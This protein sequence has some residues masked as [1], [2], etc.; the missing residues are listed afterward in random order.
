MIEQNWKTHNYTGQGTDIGSYRCWCLTGKVQHMV[1][2]RKLKWCVHFTSSPLQ[3]FW[4]SACAEQKA[5]IPQV[6]WQI[7]RH[8]TSKT[9][10][11]L[12]L[13]GSARPARWKQSGLTLVRQY[14]ASH[15]HIILGCNI[16]LLVHVLFSL[17]LTSSD[18]RKGLDRERE[19][20]RQWMVLGAEERPEGMGKRRNSCGAGREMETGMEQIHFP[21]GR[22][23]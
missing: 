13:V 18:G 22:V 4:P 8:K 23:G 2:K 12:E 7:V 20:R 11:V 10:S 14:L 1:G 16:P 6:S 17:L 9:V 15:R 5:G 3:S 21:F 19:K